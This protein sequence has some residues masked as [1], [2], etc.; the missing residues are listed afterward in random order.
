M[1]ISAAPPFK[2]DDSLLES[3]SGAGLNGGLIS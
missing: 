1:Q 3:L 2:A